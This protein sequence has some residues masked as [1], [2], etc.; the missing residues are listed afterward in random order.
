MLIKQLVE[1][2]KH[3]ITVEFRNSPRV[4]SFSERGGYLVTVMDA[5]R[6]IGESVFYESFVNEKQALAF[7]SRVVAKGL[8][9]VKKSV[10][11]EPLF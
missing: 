6:S 2:D 5:K 11:P 9:W 4:V 8:P 1:T 3:Y 7:V 10:I